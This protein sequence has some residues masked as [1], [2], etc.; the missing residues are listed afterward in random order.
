MVDKPNQKELNRSREGRVKERTPT[1]SRF[2][3]DEAQGEWCDFTLEYDSN[4][5]KVL[6][7]SIVQEAVRKSLIQQIPGIRS[8]VYVAD[9]KVQD[10]V[11]GEEV[12]RAVIHT[13]GV[14]LEAMQKY[15][16]FIN[17][18]TIKTND[19]AAVLRVYGVEA[20]RQSIILELGGVFDGHGISVDRRHLN[21]IGDYMTRNGTFTPFNRNGLK[22]NVSPFTKMSFE[23]TLSFL[24]DALLDGDWDDL[25]TPSGR[26]VMG[27]LGKIGTGAFDVLTR[28]HVKNGKNQ[29][30]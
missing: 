5:P 17:P 8:C 24:K 23:T 19:I 21:L 25:T 12:K 29:V 28:L 30:G 7:L 20:A 6:M 9:E 14:N 10:A 4:I 3:C 18:N 27:R 1:V 15:G 11:T 13:D 22:G 16:E 26:I 2:E